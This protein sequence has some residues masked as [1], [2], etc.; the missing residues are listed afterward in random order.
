MK[1]ANIEGQR[2]EAQPG[3][4]AQ[5]PLCGTTVVAK[6]GHHKVWHWAHRRAH[7]CDRWWEPET[8]WH[9]IWKNEFPSNWQEIIQ[10]APNGEKHVADV[11]TKGG[12]VIEFQH[13]FL[14]TKERMAREYFYGK[15]V[16]VVDGC[17][18]KRD[19]DQLLKSIGPCVYGIEPYILYVADHQ[20]CTLLR[21]WNTSPVPVYF[22]L[23]RREDTGELTFWRRDP[24]SH[25]GRVYLSPVS[26]D[27]FLKV[28]RDGSNNEEI[29]SEGIRIIVENR[30]RSMQRFQ[31]TSPLNFKQHRARPRNF[32]RFR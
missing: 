8:E 20:G 26:R 18:R 14:E 29:F 1:F 24:I 9:K 12:T 4:S 13:S 16:W 17:R 7:V 23:G 19:A 5:C 22:D 27:S 2:R 25:N 3:I 21:E 28:H 10:I 31:A 6:C 11:K 15:M 32:P 30:R